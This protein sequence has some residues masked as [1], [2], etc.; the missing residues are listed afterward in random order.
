MIH[1][2]PVS[3]SFRYGA[4]SRRA[5]ASSSPDFDGHA[6]GLQFGDA[7]ALDLREGIARGDDD[8]AHARGQHGPRAGR[9]L[10]VVAARFERDVERG[11]GRA[12]AGDLQGLD[13][14][15]RLAEAPMPA[16]ADDFGPLGDHAADHRVRLDEPLPSDGE[17]QG[18]THVPEVDFVLLHR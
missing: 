17:F 12:V 13:F 5:S 8:A 9:R 18:A 3:T 1:G 6:G 4:F 16:L 15:M 10:A 7:A 2:R 11:P 14:G